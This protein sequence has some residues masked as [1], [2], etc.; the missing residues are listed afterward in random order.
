MAAGNER[1]SNL[2][3]DPANIHKK[4]CLEEILSPAETFENLFSLILL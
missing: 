2:T 4:D 1:D 3:E